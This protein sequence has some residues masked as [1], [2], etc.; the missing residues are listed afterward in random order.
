MKVATIILIALA[1]SYNIALFD[2]PGCCARFTL[3]GN[4]RNLS[5]KDNAFSYSQAREQ[6]GG[7]LSARENADLLKGQAA[8]N[9]SNVK[10]AGLTGTNA[11]ENLIPNAEE[12]EREKGVFISGNEKRNLVGKENAEFVGSQAREFAMTAPTQ[13]RETAE[14]ARPD[15]LAIARNLEL[16]E[17]D[18]FAGSQ[19]REIEATGPNEPLE[20][21]ENYHTGNSARNLSVEHDWGM[22]ALEYSCSYNTIANQSRVRLLGQVN[23]E[24]VVCC[25]GAPEE[26]VLSYAHY[27]SQE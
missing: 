25:N 12:F 7:S 18:R 15:D 26:K 20:M 22:F 10:P 23:A 1:V 3:T 21:R 6:V 16:K 4:A 5:L 11:R 14:V 19:A 17:N 24:Y 9:L 27:L 8:R 2:H 13:T